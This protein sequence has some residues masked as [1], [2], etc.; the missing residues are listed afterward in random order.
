LGTMGRTPGTLVLVPALLSSY[1]MHI[2]LNCN[3]DNQYS[4]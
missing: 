1:S 4:Q 3:S 2:S